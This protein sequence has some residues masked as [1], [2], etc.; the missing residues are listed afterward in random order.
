M[1][2]PFR[3]FIHRMLVLFDD[4]SPYRAHRTHCAC[5]QRTDSMRAQDI[6][7]RLRVDGGRD[8]SC[9]SRHDR[10]LMHPSRLN[11]HW[12]REVDGPSIDIGC[13]P[14]WIS[15]SFLY[16]FKFR[17]SIMTCYRSLGL[18]L[19]CFAGGSGLFAN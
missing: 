1:P 6:F 17:S 12:H 13:E 11:E 8:A 5:A 3:I 2:K 16:L 10:L 7:A 15:F 4:G 18:A 19:L 9:F 14:F